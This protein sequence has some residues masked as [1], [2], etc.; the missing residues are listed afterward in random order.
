MERIAYVEGAMII[1][2]EYSFNE[3]KERIEEMTPDLKD[4]IIEVIKSVNASLCKTK[5][6]KEKT[7]NGQVLYSPA[8]LNKLFSAEFESRGWEKKKVECQ[9]SDSFYTKEFKEKYPKE[10]QRI[11]NAF[12]EMDFVKKSFSL[13]KELLTEEEQNVF[14]NISPDAAK[15][16]EQSVAKAVAYVILNEDF[17]GTFLIRHIYFLRKENFGT[18]GIIRMFDDLKDKYGSNDNHYEYASLWKKIFNL[19]IEKGGYKEAFFE[20]FLENYD[21]KIP[22]AYFHSANLYKERISENFGVVF[23][24]NTNF[25]GFRYDNE[26]DRLIVSLFVTYT[27]IEN[28]YDIDKI[29]SDFKRVAKDS[30]KDYEKYINSFIILTRQKQK[31]I[32]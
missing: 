17:K 20:R 18:D 24:N 11:E 10:I 12:R 6:S 3:G 9:Y 8:C 23:G 26:A 29:L 2:A 28:G 4:E 32:K 5:V 25:E 1:A 31:H 21:F 15:F 22:D 16:L 27:G 30:F 7:K 14:N 19:K 13:F